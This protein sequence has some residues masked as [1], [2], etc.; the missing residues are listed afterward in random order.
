MVK[1]GKNYVQVG[2]TSFGLDCQYKLF[3]PDVFARV[4]TH[5]KWIEEVTAEDVLS[6]DGSQAEVDPGNKTKIFESR[7]RASRLRR[8]TVW[9]GVGGGIAIFLLISFGIGV[10]FFVKW[11]DSTGG[12]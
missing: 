2:I 10:Y 11:R 9:Y 4:S 3:A 8:R 1:R 6:I 12:K 7:L 5:T